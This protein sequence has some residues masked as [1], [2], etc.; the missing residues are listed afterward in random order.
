M[1]SFGD[2]V[3]ILNIDDFDQNKLVISWLSEVLNG[4][5]TEESHISIRLPESLLQD[6]FEW[7]DDTWD[8]GDDECTDFSY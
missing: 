4:C 8:W 7:N 1:E 2:N 5:A 3:E 6:D